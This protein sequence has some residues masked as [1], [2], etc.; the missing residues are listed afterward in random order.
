MINQEKQNRLNDELEEYLNKYKVSSFKG[1]IGECKLE[2]VLNKLYSDAE[3]IP[4]L[5]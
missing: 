5:I 3:I 2:L 1:Q 4:K